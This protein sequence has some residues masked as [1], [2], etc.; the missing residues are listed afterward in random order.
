MSVKSAVRVFEIIECLV[1][2]DN[3]L[4]IKEISTRLSFPQSSTFNLV[5]TMQEMGYLIQAPDKRFKLGPKFIYIGNRT[6]ESF[7]LATGSRQHLENLMNKVGE[8]VFM[9]V[10]SGIDIVYLAKV[11][12]MQSIKTSAV[13]GSHKPLYCTG[14]GKAILAFLSEEK[15]ESLLN[16]IDL[17]PVTPHTIT[18]QTKF[19]EQ[20]DL[21]K[22]KGYAIDDEEGEEGLFCYAAPIFDATQ[23]LVAAIS[24]AGPKERITRNES[25]VVGHLLET[26]RTISESLGFFNRKR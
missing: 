2:S 5:Q 10:Q 19:V 17:K 6:L 7:D 11:D 8:T 25:V 16:Q 23:K 22:Q 24:T 13:I 18:N 15:R 21:F 1:D 4:T 20:L 3:G 12:S 9:A 26:S 14:L